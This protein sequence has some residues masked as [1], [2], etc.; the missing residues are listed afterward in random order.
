MNEI[1]AYRYRY[2]DALTWVHS[3]TE[4]ARHPNLIVEPLCV[5]RTS[6]GAKVSRE[7]AIKFL[8]RACRNWSAIPPLSNDDIEDVAKEL[9]RVCGGSNA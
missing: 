7:D 8:E 1:V 3:T 6:S 4:P 2:K 5:A 9:S